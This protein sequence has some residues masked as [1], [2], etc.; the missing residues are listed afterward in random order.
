MA[1]PPTPLY[2]YGEGGF[3]AITAFY[4][5]GN[6]TRLAPTPK[7]APWRA[8]T[9]MLGVKVSSRAKVA[10][11][12]TPMV[13]TSPKL[14]FLGFITKTA[15]KA[16]T[17]PSIRYLSTEVITSPRE[18][19]MALLYLNP[20]NFTGITALF[21]AYFKRNYLYQ[22]DPMASA[23]P[24]KE[25]FLEEDPEIRSQK[26]VLLSFLSPENVLES[27]DQYFFGEFLKQ[28]EIDYKMKNLETFLVSLVRGVNDNLTKEAERLEALSPDLSG[29]ALNC[30]KARLNM[31]NILETY[32]AYVKEN[33]ESIKKTTIKED[34]DNFMFKNQTKLEEAFFEKN[35]F[36]TS[37][38]GL[39]VRGVTGTHGEAVAMSKKLQ[40]NDPIH[41][42]FLGEVGKWLPWDPKP[43]Q[44]QDQEYAEDQLNTLMK[45]YKNNE[46]AREKFMADQRK[47]S[48][49]NMRK[50]PN[51]M[52]L[53]AASPEEVAAATADATNAPANGPAVAGDSS[54]GWGSMFSGPADLAIQRKK[55]AQ[56]ADTVPSNTLS[57]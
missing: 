30:R 22:T 5:R 24:P 55:E 33:D 51:T 1:L 26:F 43:H 46:E 7:P 39:K 23:N 48:T 35:E 57:Q 42:I 38:R 53:S 4:I 37:I 29:A 45:S 44:V 21:F 34:Y 41:N 25:D 56:Q 31:G 6:P 2:K 11:A 50:G 18:K 8:V 54:E 12:A 15:T 19:S 16:T 17:R 10:N 13:S 32:H 14:G 47:E 40:R 36:R 9:A 20:R 28:Y 3:A 52:S 27:K 49:E